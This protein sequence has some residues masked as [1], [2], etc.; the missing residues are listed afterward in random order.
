LILA[1]DGQEYRFGRFDSEKKIKW[2]SFTFVN[3]GHATQYPKKKAFHSRPPLGLDHALRS[4]AYP[5][6]L[7]LEDGRN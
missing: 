6:T 2:L 7:I 5:F 4:L 1:V 3:Q